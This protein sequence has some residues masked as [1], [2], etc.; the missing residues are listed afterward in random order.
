MSP[1]LSMPLLWASLFNR[2]GRKRAKFAATGMAPKD[3][4]KDLLKS[5]VKMKQLGKLEILIERRYSMDQIREAHIY[6]ESGRKRGNVVLG[7]AEC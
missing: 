7:V 4:I 5:L 1:V 6:V 2:E 3:T